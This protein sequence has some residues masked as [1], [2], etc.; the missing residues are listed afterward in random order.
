MCMELIWNWIN[1]RENIK[2]SDVSKKDSFIRSHQNCWG[3]IKVN[4]VVRDILIKLNKAMLEKD[5]T[6]EVYEIYDQLVMI[7]HN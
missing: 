2:S 7:M 4:L 5:N 6:K 3:S 1:V